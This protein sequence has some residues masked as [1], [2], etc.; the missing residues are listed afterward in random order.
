MSCGPRRS[1]RTGC[2][3][4]AR[5]GGV[6][7]DRLAGGLGAGLPDLGAA[8]PARGRGWRQR[9]L[10]RLRPSA[11]ARPA[12]RTRSCPAATTTPCRQVCRHLGLASRSAAAARGEAIGIYA[13]RIL[14]TP[15]RMAP[16]RLMAMACRIMSRVANISKATPAI[17]I[18]RPIWRESIGA[19]PSEVTRAGPA[20]PC[21]PRGLR[22][23]PARSS[24][25]LA[26]LK[27]PAGQVTAGQVNVRKRG[28]GVAMPAP[29]IHGNRVIRGSSPRLPPNPPRGV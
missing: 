27:F 18:P 5:P 1:S 19:T 11:R 28:V 23:P 10:P 8:G 3:R 15:S 16:A 26:R 21:R 12:G 22:G 24:Q 7:G 9:G 25:H 4:G 20:P 2:R 29:G 17:S 13:A 14:D 6:P